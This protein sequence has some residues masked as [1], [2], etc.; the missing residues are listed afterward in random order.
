[1]SLQP[2]LRH[3]SEHVGPCELC[4]LAL[5]TRVDAIG[6]KAAG[7]VA[8]LAGAPQRD[9]PQPSET[10]ELSRGRRCGTSGATRAPAAGDQQI[11]AAPIGNLAVLGELQG[12]ANGGIGQRHGLPQ[13]HE[14]P[15][16]L[17]SCQAMVSDD[18]RQ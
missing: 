18:L 7:L 10:Q 15:P 1:M 12:R 3:R 4:S 9:I 16:G 5:I 14:V 11:E 8:L 6:N 17:L 2:F 13:G